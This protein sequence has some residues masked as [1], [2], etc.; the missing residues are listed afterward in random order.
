VSRMSLAAPA[1]LHPKLLVQDKLLDSCLVG[2]C[3]T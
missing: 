1:C 3:C 2:K